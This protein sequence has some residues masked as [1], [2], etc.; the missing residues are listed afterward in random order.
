[1]GGRCLHAA[2]GKYTGDGEFGAEVHLQV[3]NH[4]GGE[5][6]ECPIPH[7]RDC[8]VRVERIDSNLR[9]DAGSRSTGVLS[10]E[11]CRGTAL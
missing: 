2:D 8:G 9:V 10:P 4:E 3:P 6:P 1:M 11:I 7:A 5:D